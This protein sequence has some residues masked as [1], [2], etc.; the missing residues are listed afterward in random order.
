[1][2]D[3]TLRALVA[4]FDDE[5][6]GTFAK[7]VARAIDARIRAVCG[8]VMRTSG[9]AA[10]PA[11]ERRTADEPAF[12]APP[13]GPEEGGDS[14][15]KCSHPATCGGTEGMPFWCVQCGAIQWNRDL[16]WKVP[17]W[18]RVGPGSAVTHARWEALLAERDEL[19]AKLADMHEDYEASQDARAQN[20]ADRAAAIARAEAAEA[21]RDELSRSVCGFLD[22]WHISH[23]RHWDKTMQRGAGCPACI[24]ERRLKDELCTALA[25]LSPKPGG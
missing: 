16:P 9:G 14:T 18:R 15:N 25:R 4:V 6:E 12:H 3:E 22:S 21:Q 13:R 5:W 17:E 1:M 20:A 2:S 7:D 8:E 23:G 19:R 11:G 24:D 10:T